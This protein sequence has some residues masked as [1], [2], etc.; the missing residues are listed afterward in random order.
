VPPLRLAVP[1]VAAA[2]ALIF[3]V[4]RFVGLVNH[5]SAANDFRLFY[6]AAQAGVQVGLAR[7]Y[8][9]VWLQHFSFAF[10]ASA[11]ITPAYTYDFPPLLAWMVIPLTFLPLAAAFYVWTGVNLVS[12]AAASR[13][14]FRD[15]TFRWVTVLMV[16]LALWP[17]VFS[18]ERGQPELIVYALAVGSW[19]LA[20]NRRD[21]WAGVVLGLAWAI[22][23]QIVLLLPAVFLLCGRPRA[24]AWWL[25]TTAVAWCVFVLA[26]GRSG[27]AVYL[28][29]LQWA[30]SDPGFA[31]APIVAPFGPALSLLLGQALFAVISLAA[32]WRQRASLEMGFAI[33]LVGTLAS[34]VHLHEYDYVGLIAAAWFV[35]IAARVSVI[36]MAWMAV[37]AVC[38]QLPAIG[39][40]WPIVLFA[41]LWLLWL[42]VRPLEAA[43]TIPSSQRASS[44]MRSGVQTGS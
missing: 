7:M 38:C 35:I 36:D 12:F 32:V 26:L 3:E 39:I 37:G 17:A 42:W 2:W 40:R 41:P 6:V 8:D 11:P 19:W 9:P 14:A 23:P 30:A 44:D 13:L 24:A 1:A 22:K 21:R 16:S 28:Y 20:A 31:A 29:A 18:L 10:V 4:P 15:N 25:L 43:Q 33:G 5:D 34:A 27:M